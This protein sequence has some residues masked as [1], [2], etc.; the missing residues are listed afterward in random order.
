MKIVR[1][2]VGTIMMVVVASGLVASELRGEC[3]PIS[4]HEIMC[5]VCGELSCCATV[6]STIPSS[7]PEPLQVLC[8]D[9]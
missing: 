2:F 1:S 9:L 7:D 3:L 5:L 8:W 6:Y 4:E